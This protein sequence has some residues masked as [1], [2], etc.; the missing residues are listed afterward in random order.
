MMLC[1]SPA[2]LSGPASPGSRQPHVVRPL[3]WRTRLLPGHPAPQPLLPWALG[4][5][6]ILDGAYGDRGL[7]SHPGHMQWAAQARV[8]VSVRA[9]P[10]GGDTVGFIYGLLMPLSTEDLA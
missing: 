10:Q 5:A 3:L 6:D 1:P 2:S 4:R 7:R 8:P 9:Q